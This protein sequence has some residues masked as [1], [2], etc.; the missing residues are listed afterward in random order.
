[1][2]EDKESVEF[3]PGTDDK[4]PGT[5]WT[6]Y[7]A[8]I[9]RRQGLWIGVVVI[10]ITA[11]FAGRACAPGASPADEHADH[12]HGEEE[13]ASEYV[14][15]MHPQVRQSEPGTC[16]IC[17]MDL[18]PVESGGAGGDIPGVSLTPGAKALARVQTAKAEAVELSRSVD[19]Y[20]RVEVN[21]TA[22]VDLTAWAGG[23]IDK[24]YVQA[25][26]E[27][28]KKGQRLARIYSPDLLAAQQ[29]LVQAS[30]NLESSQESGSDMRGRAAQAALEAA[31]TELRLL[32]MSARQLDA[33]LKG[34]KA[35]EFVDIFASSAGTVRERVV[36]QGDW[37]QP[38]GRVL[39]LMALDTVWVQLDVYERDLPVVQV[40]QTVTLD[41][42]A[43]SQEAV[44]GEIAFIDPVI[45]AQKR[46]A[47][48]RVVLKNAD[49]KLRPGMFVTGRIEAALL[50]DA[51]VPLS[52]P[53]TAV[54]WT[55]KRSLVYRVE[56]HN[57]EPVYVPAP[58]VLGARVGGRFVIVEGLSEGD[59]VV[60]HG[61]FRLDAS[62]Q[63]RGG[64]TMMSTETHDD[65][66]AHAH[67]EALPKVEVPLEGAEFDPPVQPEQL[68]DDVWYCDMGT[69]HYAR[70]EEGD[71]ICPLCNMQLKH[72][73]AGSEEGEEHKDHENQVESGGEH[74]H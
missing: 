23:R 20:G 19:V 36:S 10:V 60:S 58:V 44:E 2:S 28:V 26:G 63:I 21:E 57:G 9:K 55:G 32:G 33:V 62:L 71:G 68:P 11:F 56:D 53:A 27:K 30:R 29:T 59:E 51:Q 38:G 45:D 14:C 6:G 46:V 61:A 54:L 24:L 39:S 52:V 16:P 43:L 73:T 31:R 7:L 8:R 47:R 12:Q 37:V 72:K 42:P 65:H 3:E 15:P 34:G 40:G 50:D 5:A 25:V 70:G 74:A 64:P 18:V 13:A 48:A 67:G 66:A 35:Q 17:F 22:E 49:A 69:A 1:M 4:A 41:I